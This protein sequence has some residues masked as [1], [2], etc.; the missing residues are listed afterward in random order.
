MSRK[1]ITVNHDVVALF[2]AIKQVFLIHYTTGKK[3]PFLSSTYYFYCLVCPHS[4]EVL[5]SSLKYST[6][7]YS[8]LALLCFTV[9]FFFSS[10]VA[11]IFWSF[12]AVPFS[13][14]KE[15]AWYKSSISESNTISARSV[16]TYCYTVATALAG[17]FFLTRRE[18]SHKRSVA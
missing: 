15:L 4:K 1:T 11:I 8:S 14:I 5:A 10:S 18:L 6:D 13:V 17:F 7:N 3:D 2:I 16:L 12:F 9:T